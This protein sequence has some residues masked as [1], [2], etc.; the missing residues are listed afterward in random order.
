MLVRKVA[1]SF[2][3][4]IAPRLSESWN[5]PAERFH[6]RPQIEVYCSLEML[7]GR[8]EFWCFQPTPFVI[9]ENKRFSHGSIGVVKSRFTAALRCCLSVL[10]FGVFGNWGAPPRWLLKN[11][12]TVGTRGPPASV[13]QERSGILTGG[14]QWGDQMR[15]VPIVPSM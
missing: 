13:L 2:E 1:S 6:R 15:K 9:N 3:H 14:E 7:F 4:P 11:G 12:A 8:F 10:S 5:A